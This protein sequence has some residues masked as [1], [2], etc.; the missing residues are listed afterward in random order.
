MEE[1][2]FVVE[3]AK[4]LTEALDAGAEVECVFVSDD[5]AEL[6]IVDRVAS[7][8]IEVVRVESTAF[9]RVTDVVSPQPV[10]AIVRRPLTSVA[11]LRAGLAAGGFVIIGVDT[12]RPR[13][14]FIFT[15]RLT[16]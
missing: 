4:V 14:S 9:A 10:C 2:V 7:L 13:N 15:L 11:D 6:A 16:L 3:G 8:G 5:A 1:G 12:R